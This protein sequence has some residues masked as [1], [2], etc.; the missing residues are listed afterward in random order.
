VLRVA[1]DAV[2]AEALVDRV[3]YD[4]LNDRVRVTDQRCRI[5]GAVQAIARTR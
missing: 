1:I 5:T 3:P 4:A 2:R